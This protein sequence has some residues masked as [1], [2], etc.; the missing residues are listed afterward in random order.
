[1]AD[2]STNW[3]MVKGLC[4]ETETPGSGLYLDELPGMGKWKLE[5]ASD[6][7]WVD[8]SE[9]W[10]KI[11][12][13]ALRNMAQDVRANMI[14]K[15]RV[16]NVLANVVVGEYYPEY[17]AVI[18]T[19][20]YQGVFV[21]VQGSQYLDLYLNLVQVY[22]SA[23]GSVPVYVFDAQTGDQLYTKT[24]TGSAGHNAFQ[25]NQNFTTTGQNRE[26]FI[27]YDDT[28][29]TSYRTNDDFPAWNTNY[30]WYLITQGGSVAKASQV[31]QSNL[32][33]NGQTGGLVANF[34]L[35]C[36][37]DAFM[38]QHRHPLANALLYKCGVETARELYE[39]DEVISR[40]TLLTK[41]EA[42]ERIQHFESEYTRALGAVLEVV[43]PVIDEVCFHCRPAVDWKVNI[44]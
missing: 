1:M 29:I 19:G 43:E 17:E 12:R 25:V 39:N 37:I 18:G 22:L 6:P 38:C 34:N 14:K 30:E 11:Y 44:P 15:I 24:F 26:Y 23:G 33:L 40:Y 35:I 9:V 2:W 31:I 36:S 10:D 4:K 13:R 41:E 5:A 8:F 7:S 27:C 28:G 3:I 32:S 21:R 16:S 42:G 20:R